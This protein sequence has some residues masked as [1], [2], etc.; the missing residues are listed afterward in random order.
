M[1]SGILE[2]V[3]RISWGSRLYILAGA[4]I[5]LSA[6]LPTGWKAVVG[7]PAIA[8]FTLGFGLH[9]WP[10]VRRAW[11]HPAGKVLISVIHVA[12]VLAA[13]ILATKVVAASLGLPPEKFSSTVHILSLILLG[14]VWALLAG[15]VLT[16]MSFSV[17]LWSLRKSAPHH[18]L[19]HIG[20]FMGMFCWAMLLLFLAEPVNSWVRKPPSWVTGIAYFVDFHELPKMPGVGP[21]EHVVVL[22]NDQLAIGTFKDGAVT[23]TVRPA[24]T[25]D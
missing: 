14:P 3:R 24:K 10:I 16:V 5:V 25:T 20:H 11:S 6:V 23:V 13:H 7:V 2:S 21:G 9:A 22:D 18:G 12:I 8:A 15:V 19:V 17:F 4:A 1:E